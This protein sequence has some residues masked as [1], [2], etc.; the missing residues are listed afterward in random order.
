MAAGKVVF[1]GAPEELTRETVRMI[2]GAEADGEEISESMTSTSI[3]PGISQA[4]LRKPA[5][6][7]RPAL[8]AH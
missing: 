2:Y 4:I 5:P 7:R 3:D 6:S 1:D 8:A